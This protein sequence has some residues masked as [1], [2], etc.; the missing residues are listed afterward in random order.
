MEPPGGNADL[1]AKTKL[2]AI[3]ELGR[4]VAHQDGTV[5]PLK[6]PLGGGVI[7]GQDA[8]GVLAAIAAD[9]GNRPIHPI[10]DPGRDDHV[11]KLA[12]EILRPR[13]HRARHCQQIALGPHLDRKEHAPVVS[14]NDQPLPDPRAADTPWPSADA[15]Y[16]SL[17][18]DVS[19][20]PLIVN[21]PDTGGRYSVLSAL[22]GIGI[23]SHTLDAW[24]VPLALVVLKDGEGIAE[25]QLLVDLV[26][27]VRDEIGP[28]ACFNQVRLVKRLPKTRSGKILRAVLRKIADGQD[29]VPPSTLD[30]PAVLGEIEAVLADLPRAG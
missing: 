23:V 15:L 19:Q 16:S 12:P 1:R 9:M 13:R 4:G 26:G 28:L 2:A 14:E 29:Y 24:V 17:W 8:F 10:D 25:A 7:L 5:E 18:F 3:G 22:E 20:A 27:R 30:D 6:E 11:Q 21:L